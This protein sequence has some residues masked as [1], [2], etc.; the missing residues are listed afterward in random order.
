MNTIDI[1][2]LLDK[3]GIP[4]SSIEQSTIENYG[5]KFYGNTN[6]NCYMCTKGDRLF[7]KGKYSEN[8]LKTGFVTYHGIKNSEELKIK[9]ELAAV[10][11]DGEFIELV[12]LDGS[13]DPKFTNIMIKVLIELQSSYKIVDI[14]HVSHAGSPITTTTFTLKRI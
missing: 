2:K 11:H 8:Y 3:H 9:R 1:I 10:F 13:R 6:G 7:T 4:F 12:T 14:S 5:N